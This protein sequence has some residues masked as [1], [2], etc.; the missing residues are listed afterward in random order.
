MLGANYVNC[1]ATATAASTTVTV[2]LAGATCSVGNSKTT[3]MTIQGLTNPTQAVAIA[4]ANFSV[5]TSVDNTSAVSPAANVTITAGAFSKLQL[6]MPGEAAA[7]GTASGKTGSPSARTAGTSFNVIVNAV[8]ANWNKVATV[9]DT[10]GLTSSDGQATLPANTAL[11]AGT[12]TLAVTLKTAPTQTVTAS[13]VTDGTKTANTSP[14]TTVNPLRRLEAVGEVG[15]GECDGGFELLGAGG[16]GRCVWECGECDLCDGD[17]VVGVGLGGAVW[18]CGLD[19]ERDEQCDVVVGAVHE[20][21]VDHVDCDAH[22]GDG[23]CGFGGECE[24][25]GRPGGGGDV[26]VVGDAGFGHGGELRAR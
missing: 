1:T 17:L 10:V 19:R 25:H 26:D 20:G 24:L 14:G 5:M 11:V 15:A 13:D 3:A 23:A 7:A 4:K 6:L 9:T 2:T 16:F 22:V 8:D 21:G 18:E 12:K